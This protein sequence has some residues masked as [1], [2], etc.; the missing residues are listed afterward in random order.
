MKT[1]VFS[2]TLLVFALA[3]CKKDEII[4]PEPFCHLVSETVDYV[5]ASSSNHYTILY[6]YNADHQLVGESSG[7]TYTW[8]DLEMVRRTFT[9]VGALL[10]KATYTLDNAGRTVSI[11][12][13]DGSQNFVYYRSYQYDANG[14]LA[15]ASQTGTVS[16]TTT[17]EWI[18]G[19]LF[20][21][22]NT[23]PFGDVITTTYSYGLQLPAPSSYT[24]LPLYGKAS[25]YLSTHSESIY[26]L[27]YWTTAD[28][29]Y[30]FDQYGNVQKSILNFVDTGVASTLITQYTY[31][32]CE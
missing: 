28:T 14:Y 9:N 25:K 29:Q 13:V 11:N 22:I 5:S 23:S 4:P 19:N 16:H 8:S 12:A 32:G 24:N 21:T 30:E 26:S 15:S 17:Y 20:K 18:D 27:G 1:I 31:E 6:T 3:S 2:T 10:E 7:V